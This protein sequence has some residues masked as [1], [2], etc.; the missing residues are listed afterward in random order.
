MLKG[1][2]PWLSIDST[3]SEPPDIHR[4]NYDGE[5]YVLVPP[6][7]TSTSTMFR[8][9][10]VNHFPAAF[11]PSLATGQNLVL[12]FSQLS[13]EKYFRFPSLRTCLKSCI[14]EWRP[15]CLFSIKSAQILLSLPPVCDDQGR[16]NNLRVTGLARLATATNQEYYRYLVLIDDTSLEYHTSVH[17]NL[18]IGN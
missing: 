15:E 18:S 10:P 6:P 7:T 8:R 16:A 13:H 1:S 11:A 2:W 14:V 4:K 12:N 5:D 9:Q 3:L 17:W